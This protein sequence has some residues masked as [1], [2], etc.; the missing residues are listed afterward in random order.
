MRANTVPPA[1]GERRPLPLPAMPAAILDSCSLASLQIGGP[2]LRSLGI[3]SAIR[4]EGRST[5]ALAMTLVQRQD[6]DRR[7]LLVEMDLE[8]P[9]LGRRLGLHSTP[10]LSELVRGHAT[11][12]EAIQWIDGIRVVT[13]GASLGRPDRVIVELLACDVLARLGESCDVMVVDLPAVS[14]CSF[15]A[16]AAGT[17]DALLLVVRAGVTPA[18]RIRE[19]VADLPSRPAVLLNGTER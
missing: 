9:C 15:A 10:G 4:G 11:L 12:D 2:T 16:L 13:A 5:V 8:H 19:A 3:T 14:G 18:A 17:V 6:Y 1:L 7:P